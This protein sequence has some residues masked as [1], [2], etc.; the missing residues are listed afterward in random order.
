MAL[1]GDPDLLDR[2]H[3]VDRRKDRFA[4]DERDLTHLTIH[5]GTRSSQRDTSVPRDSNLRSRAG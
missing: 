4:R 2:R 1:E 3:R 5:T